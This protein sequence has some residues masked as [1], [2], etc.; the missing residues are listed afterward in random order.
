MDKTIRL[1][2]LTMI[3]SGIIF[4]GCEKTPEL[5]TKIES[6][7]VKEEAKEELVEKSTEKSAEKPASEPV[8][9]AQPTTTPTLQLKE[10]EKEEVTMY[11]DGSYSQAGTYQSPAGAE[12][13]N[14]S[15]TVKD[16][17]VTGLTV[18]PSAQNE[19]SKKFQ[20]LFVA[21]INQMVVGKKLSEVGSFGQVNGS[22]LTPQGFV[23]AVAG[24]KAQAQN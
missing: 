9:N 15:L 24:I 13:V 12:S 19:T 2:L 23:S 1:F 8:K 6:E 11:K 22:S 20:G 10:E 5:T 17:V 18:T 21:G 14:V 7:V 4:T 16:D 3:I